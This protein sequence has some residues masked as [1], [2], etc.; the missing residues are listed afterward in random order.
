GNQL[1]HGGPRT[2]DPGERELVGLRVEACRV[3]VRPLAGRQLLPVPGQAQ[4]CGR[5]DRPPAR[6]LGPSEYPFTATQVEAPPDV[7]RHAGATTEKSHGP[8]LA[9]GS[10]GARGPVA[11]PVRAADS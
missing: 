6:Q 4:A 9:A 2:V 7:V 10:L 3:D 5:R 11:Q 1:Q 8:N